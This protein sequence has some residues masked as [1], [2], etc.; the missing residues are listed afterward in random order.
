MGTKERRQR[1]VAGREQRILE[2]AR[3]LI[4][5][6]G[7][8]NLQMSRLAEKCEYAVGTLYQHFASKEDLL[9]ALT[10]ENVQH[11]AELF[12]RVAHWQAGTR[13]RM[14]G[15]AVA[16]MILV[17]RYPEHFRLDQYAFTEVV[18]GAA[19]P[20]RRREALEA[21]EPLGRI[22]ESIVTEAARAGDVDIKGLKSFELCL[23][24]WAL[25]EGTHQIAHAEG[26]VEKYGLGNAYRLML[27]HQ[28]S[29]LNGL[30]WKPLFDAADD[31][32]LDAK[33]EKLCNEVFH[34]LH[35]ET[36]A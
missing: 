19:S 20:E 18:W 6:D 10:I 2:T 24:P 33:I 15:I 29:L 12:E 26:L 13:D 27:R 9:V 11:R 8:L 31:K 3:E 22:V 34:D 25:C 5:Q 28:Q 36:T 1:E 7:L 14:F 30:G 21:S 17:R 35:C 4:R 32:A 23:A 16:D